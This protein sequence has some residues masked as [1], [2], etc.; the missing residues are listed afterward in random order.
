MCVMWPWVVRWSFHPEPQPP[1][2]RPMDATT[3]TFS[4]VASSSGKSRAKASRMAW[5]AMVAISAV[6]PSEVP[7]RALLMSMSAD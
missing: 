5:T 3:P 1:S 4:S 7:A 2:C 6:A